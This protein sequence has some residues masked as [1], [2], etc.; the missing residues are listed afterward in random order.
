MKK[1]N[2]KKFNLQLFLSHAKKITDTINATKKFGGST[3]NLITNEA[4]SNVKTDDFIRINEKRNTISIFVPTTMNVDK[5][6]T[7]EKIAHMLQVVD[8]KMRKIHNVPTIHEICIGSWYC[9]ELDKVVTEKIYMVSQPISNLSEIEIGLYLEVAKYTK[10]A[11][12]QKFVS[13]KIN[14]A[15]LLT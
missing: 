12:N 4:W 10:K 1:I 7:D 15:L 13:M 14:N 9:K 3:H 8:N 11:M 6:A 2:S 5:L